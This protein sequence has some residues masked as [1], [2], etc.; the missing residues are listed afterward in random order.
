MGL[1][2]GNGKGANTRIGWYNGANTDRN[3]GQE[4]RF[5]YTKETVKNLRDQPECEQ[6]LNKLCIYIQGNTY[7]SHPKLAGSHLDFYNLTSIY[8]C[9]KI[10]IM[11]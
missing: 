1:V 10:V 8:T 6:M 9:L 4:S 11:Y 7:R 3:Q 5:L 2:N